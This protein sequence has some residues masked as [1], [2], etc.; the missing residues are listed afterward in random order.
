MV[1]QGEI[2]GINDHGVREDGGVDIIASSVQVIV[3]REGISRSYPHSWGDLPDDVKVLKEEGPASLATREF[4]RVLEIGQVLVVGENGNGVCGALQ[5]LFPFC[6]GKND[7]QEF[8]VIDVIIPFCSREGF[9]EVSTGMEIARSIRLHRDCTSCEERGIWHE[10]E[11]AQEI[12]DAK[13]RSRQENGIQGVES[14]LLGLSP[15]PRVVF[16][17]EKDNGC[18]NVGVVGNELVIEVCKSEEGVDSL[19][20][21]QG[22][23]VPDGG[24]FHRVHVNKT[25]D[26]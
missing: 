7:Y 20:R 25:L 18:N 16:M 10:Q 24:K 15:R 4:V 17:S 19:D 6:Q 5:V 26:Q 11:G 3:T 8:M 1:R 9:R 14:F 23:P 22:M 12:R 21:G 13:D 2:K